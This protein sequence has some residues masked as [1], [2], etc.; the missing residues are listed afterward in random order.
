[1]KDFELLVGKLI[2]AE[3]GRR[4]HKLPATASFSVT[5]RK[6]SFI[7]T[8]MFGKDDYRLSTTIVLLFIKIDV[9]GSVEIHEYV[10]INNMEI[11]CLIHAKGKSTGCVRLRQCSTGA[12]R[13][14]L[15]YCAGELE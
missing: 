14:G 12:I 10:F 1:M 7:V 6:N 3:V 2:A 8:V 4:L 11:T 9:T 5:F 15:K 13:H